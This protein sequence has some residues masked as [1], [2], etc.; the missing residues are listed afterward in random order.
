MTITPTPITSWYSAFESNFIE[1][2]INIPFIILKAIPYWVWGLIILILVL[3]ILERRK[4]KSK[5]N[6]KF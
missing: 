6:R 3:L 4:Y 1:G 5:K 2:L